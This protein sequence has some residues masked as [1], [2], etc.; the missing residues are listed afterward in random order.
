MAAC[1]DIFGLK[2]A[3][4]AAMIDI[5][6]LKPALMAAMIDSFGLKLALM[7][8]MIDS[9]G[10]KLGVMAAM[11]DSFGLKLGVM[12]AMRGSC[13]SKSSSRRGHKRQFAA[14]NVLAGR[15]EREFQSLE[16]SVLPNLVGTGGTG[17]IRS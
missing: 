2:L 7:A 12:A 16:I 13:V 6:G 17:E 9:F 1:N 4:M 8:A 11:I 15:L 14:R 10:L 5:F 3:L